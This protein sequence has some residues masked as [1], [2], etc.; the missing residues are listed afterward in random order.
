[1]CAACDPLFVHAWTKSYRDFVLER[2]CCAVGMCAGM[3]RSVC[4][5]TLPEA[6]VL[7]VQ[8]QLFLIK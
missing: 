7:I 5:M 2:A 4:N 1:M 8:T 6:V 3:C